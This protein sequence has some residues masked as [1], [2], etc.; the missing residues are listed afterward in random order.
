MNIPTHIKLQHSHLIY[1]CGAFF[2]KSVIVF[3]LLLSI[4]HNIHTINI[5]RHP[6]QALKVGF[7]QITKSYIDH[8]L[9]SLLEQ[10]ILHYKK[11]W[12]KD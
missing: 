4:I 6:Q 5:S 7:S 10:F 12:L 2:D 9:A 11:I 8:S 1:N 3:L